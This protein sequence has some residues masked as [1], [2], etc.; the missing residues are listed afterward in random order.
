MAIDV[1]AVPI[2]MGSRTHEGSVAA[3]TTARPCPIAALAWII[4]QRPD[5]TPRSGLAAETVGEHATSEG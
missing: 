5:P 1:P 2:T 3:S 4:H